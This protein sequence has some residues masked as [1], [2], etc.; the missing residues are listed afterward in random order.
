[1]TSPDDPALP[2]SLARARALGD[3][4]SVAAHY[5]TWAE[6]YDH[7]VFEVAGVTGTEQI[8]ALLAGRLSDRLAAVI[9]L[10]CGTGRAGV[11]LREHG[12][13]TVDG[14]DLSSEMLDVARRTGAYRHLVVADLTRPLPLAPASY[15]ASI[16]AGLFT[17]G[18][19][20][21]D[22][23]EP[24]VQLVRPGGVLAWVVADPMWTDVEPEL[25]RTGALPQWIEHTAIR[26][27][28][29][30]EAHLVLARVAA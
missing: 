16:A 2:A 8:A 25:R 14:V 7:D 12:F 24:L 4:A 15:D 18:H 21:P 27:D 1:V 11:H 26:R 19:L 10:G 20:G 30:P 5:A 17:S 29:P 6:R 23:V 22:A 13:V 28:G 3:P 9:D